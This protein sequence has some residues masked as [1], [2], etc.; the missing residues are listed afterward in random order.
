MNDP[1]LIA[2]WNYSGH[3]KIIPPNPRSQITY[4]GCVALCGTGND[5]YPWSTSSSFITTWVLPVIGTL[6][7]APFESNA[8]WRTCKAIYRWIG[9]P[10]ASLAYI[11]WNIEVSGKCA[12][13]GQ[14][15]LRVT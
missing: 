11:L 12:L 9:S 14:S 5:W 4:E 8:F 13:F 6:L 2:W 10:M 15:N 7:Q 3:V 1:A